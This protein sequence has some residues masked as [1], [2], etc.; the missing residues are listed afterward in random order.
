MINL[1]GL[2]R[3]QVQHLLLERSIEFFWLASKSQQCS[4][5]LLNLIVLFFLLLGIGSHCPQLISWLL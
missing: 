4:L 3:A 2:H 5:I 1:Y